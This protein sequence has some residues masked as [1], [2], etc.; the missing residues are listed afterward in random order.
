MT[1][2]IPIS[3]EIRKLATEMVD[4]KESRLLEDGSSAKEK[5]F[6]KMPNAKPPRRKSFNVSDTRDY[7]NDYQKEYR[8]ENGNGYIPKGPK[9]GKEDKDG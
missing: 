1:K 6:L 4:T 2:K 5:P 7:R 8:L 9:K 3:E